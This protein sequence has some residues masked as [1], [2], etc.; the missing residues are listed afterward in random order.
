MLEIYLT[1]HGQDEDNQKGVLNGRRDK[2]LARLGLEQAGELAQKIKESGIKF[3]KVYT[4]P[5]QR[6][7]KTAEI[8]TDKLNLKKPEKIEDLVERD[9]GK[10]SGLLITEAAI[11]SRPNTIKT[12]TVEYFLEPEEGETFPDV[13]IRASKVLNEIKKKHRNGKILLVAHSDIG[14]MIYAA[15]YNLDWKDVLKMFHFGNSDLLILSENSKPED[16]HI[17]QLEQHNL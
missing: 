7:Y 13:S 9:F 1:R 8:I 3:D 12:N 6:A 16:V 5:L 17:F 4:S 2:P 11:I 14:K 10:L 15:Y